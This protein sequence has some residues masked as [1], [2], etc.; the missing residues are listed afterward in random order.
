MKLKSE[1]RR[2]DDI[3]NA[4]SLILSLLMLL[5]FISLNSLD[6]DNFFHLL[7]QILNIDRN[8]VPINCD[9]TL[10]KIH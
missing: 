7:A 1:M 4:A 2:K 5:T 8:I 10:R 6:L 3:K 9:Q